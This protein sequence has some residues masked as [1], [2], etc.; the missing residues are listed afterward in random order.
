[1]LAHLYSVIHTHAHNLE[2]AITPLVAAR[3]E[4]YLGHPKFCPHGSP[5]PGVKHLHTSLLPLSEVS[6]G[7]KIEVAMLD[8]SIEDEEDLLKYLQDSL[9]MPGQQHTVQERI[10]VAHTLVLQ[11]EN[12]L[13]NLPYDI[14]S[15]IN[16]REIC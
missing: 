9:V 3:L 2:H 14:A 16:V 12:R 1:M 10:D 13:T 15:L 8:E 4:E 5:M 7:T 11:S 6:T